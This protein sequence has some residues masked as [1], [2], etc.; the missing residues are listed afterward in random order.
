MTRT[1]NECVLLCVNCI[2][3]MCNN[4]KKKLFFH[5]NIYFSDIELTKDFCYI[6]D[7][8]YIRVEFL[9]SIILIITDIIQDIE[10]YLGKEND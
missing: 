4:H 6:M 1:C 5:I 8:D 7:N 9:W 2:I 3:I 10:L